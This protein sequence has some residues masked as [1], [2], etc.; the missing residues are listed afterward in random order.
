MKINY[1]LILNASFFITACG[2]GNTEQSY[3]YTLYRNVPSDP[4]FRAHVATFNSKSYSN[5]E[6][7]DEL[8]NKKNCEL[9]QSMYEKLPDWSNLKFWCERGL[10]QK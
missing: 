4:A 1:L 3:S 9:V 6:E 5:G 8:M 2:S 7:L 10:F